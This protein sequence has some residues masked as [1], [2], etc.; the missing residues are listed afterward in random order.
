MR[1]RC[2]AESAKKQTQTRAELRKFMSRQPLIA[3]VRLVDAAGRVLAD[4]R[5]G[6]SPLEQEALML[7]EHLESNPGPADSATCFDVAQSEA[8]VLIAQTR[9]TASQRF[10]DRLLIGESFTGIA[11]R[12]DRR[13]RWGIRSA[14]VCV[15]RECAGAGRCGR[16]RASLT[17]VGVGQHLLVIRSESPLSDSSWRVGLA[18]PASGLYA[19]TWQLCLVLTAIAIAATPWSPSPPGG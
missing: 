5:P 13:R 8:I 12:P 7:L 9:D 4:T 6:Q 10:L 18:I 1:S 11:L 16:R 15:H 19:S 3:R 2:A 14:S 17:A